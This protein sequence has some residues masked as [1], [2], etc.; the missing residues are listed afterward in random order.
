MQPPAGEAPQGPGGPVGA[1]SPTGAAGSGAGNAT[2]VLV[3]GI[4]S[5]VCCCLPLGPVVWYL[6]REEL[7]GIAEG[8]IPAVNEG[9]AKA[10]LILGIITTCFLCFALLWIFFFGGLTVL[11]ALAGALER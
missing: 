1:A 11:G 7:R 2:L 9:T 8:R 3:L 4:I 10:G 5:L 6:G